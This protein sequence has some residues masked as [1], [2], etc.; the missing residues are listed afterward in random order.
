MKVLFSLLP[1]LSSA[2]LPGAT[3]Y[4]DTHAVQEVGT[5]TKTHRLTTI[6]EGII[7][8]VLLSVAPVANAADVANGELI[9]KQNCVSCHKNG[10]NVIAKQRPLQKEALEKFLRMEGPDD[11]VFFVKNS[12]LHRGALAF[13]SRMTGE[14]YKDVSAYVYDQAMEDKW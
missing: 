3:T 8:A 4:R 13:A 6:A 7:A 14:D 5:E 1:C 2:F 12:D 11:I 10:V 9:F